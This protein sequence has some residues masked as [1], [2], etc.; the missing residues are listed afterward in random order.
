MVQH[1][2]KQLFFCHSQKAGG[3][4]TDT[5][6]LPPKGSISKPKSRKYFLFAFS[7]FS[8]SRLSET[9][10][11]DLHTGTGCSG[12]ETAL[13]IAHNILFMG[14]MLVND[15]KIIFELYQPV[16]VKQLSDQPVA[17]SGF[18]GKKPFFEKF[19][20]FLAFPVPGFDRL[21]VY[22]RR[23]RFGRFS[24]ITSGSAVSTAEVSFSVLQCAGK[25]FLFF[26]CKGLR[27][28]YGIFP[29]RTHMPVFICKRI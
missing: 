5:V 1:F 4:R 13:R 18:R 17:A 27:S 22:L 10:S 12:T 28:I 9:I 15:I 24:D 6:L 25:H 3:N 19:Q 16:G 20:L 26:F 11:G 29:Q 14:R 7:R 8:S 21:A 23:C 2:Q